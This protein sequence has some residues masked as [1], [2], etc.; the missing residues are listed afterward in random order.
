VHETPIVPP[1]PPP[2]VTVVDITHAPERSGAPLTVHNISRLETSSGSSRSDGPASTYAPAPT[3]VSGPLAAHSYTT[4]LHP[5]GPTGRTVA[6]RPKTLEIETPA[7]TLP[8]GGDKIARA[9]E[10][11]IKA[12]KI[13]T[14]KEIRAEHTH[15][16][17]DE[18]EAFKARVKAEELKKKVEDKEW[19]ERLKVEERELK[20]R[21]ERENNRI[22]VGKNQKGEIILIKG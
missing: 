2:D 22:R 21:E 5:P 19:K 10:K 20:K 13:A 17:K 7:F 8:G 12:E 14:Q 16:A 9:E 11:A 4:P 3:V 18:H 15:R 6:I 1:P